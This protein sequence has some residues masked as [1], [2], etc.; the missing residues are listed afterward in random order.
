MGDRQPWTVAPPDAD[1][2]EGDELGGERV[3]VVDGFGAGIENARRNNGVRE[4]ERELW[5]S[6]DIWG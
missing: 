3:E 4:G 2:D 6:R 1:E 5:S